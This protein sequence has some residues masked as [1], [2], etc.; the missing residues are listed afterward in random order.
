VTLRAPGG[1][2]Q[3]MLDV[4]RASRFAGPVLQKGDTLQN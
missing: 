1:M 4:A 2:V 3:N